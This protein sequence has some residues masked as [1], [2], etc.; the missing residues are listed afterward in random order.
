M[1]GNSGGCCFSNTVIKLIYSLQKSYSFTLTRQIVGALWELNFYQTSQNSSQIRS[2]ICH[3]AQM[4]LDCVCLGRIDWLIVAVEWFVP[5]CQRH[6]SLTRHPTWLSLPSNGSLR[7]HRHR[8]CCGKLSG[9]GLGV[10]SQA[11][12][13]CVVV[14]GKM[15]QST[16]ADILVWE[17]LLR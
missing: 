3:K 9:K 8:S 10:S 15:T 14:L 2:K 11:Q 4:I 5:G 13:L 17:S 1:L 6:S 16:L 12:A 7:N